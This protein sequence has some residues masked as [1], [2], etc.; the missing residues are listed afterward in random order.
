MRDAAIRFG[1]ELEEP[2]FRTPCPR[3]MQV[4]LRIASAI[5]GKN[6]GSILRES[7]ALWLRSSPDPSVARLVS[8][9]DLAG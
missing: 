6:H 3:D 8:D 1:A 9:L 2:T 5:T 7:L 4:P